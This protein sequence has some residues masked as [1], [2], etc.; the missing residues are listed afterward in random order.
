MLCVKKEFYNKAVARHWARDWRALA[1]TQ[2]HQKECAER[3]KEKEP[4][5]RGGARWM[6]GAVEQRRGAGVRRAA[7]SGATR[8]LRQRFAAA[9][10]VRFLCVFVSKGYL[11]SAQEKG[12]FR[13][14]G[15]VRAAV[16]PRAS[17]VRLYRRA[18]SQ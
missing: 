13:P 10:A 9:P 11:L 2:V 15:S 1:L 3:S 4:A 8:G 5:A 12:R 7:V 14:F 16:A 18:R 6:N 17:D